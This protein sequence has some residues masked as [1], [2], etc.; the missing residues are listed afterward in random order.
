M[1]SNLADDRQGMI[2]WYHTVTLVVLQLLRI[3]LKTLQCFTDFHKYGS[4]L[5]PHSSPPPK[6][7]PGRKANVQ[8]H[9]KAKLCENKIPRRKP[10]FYKKKLQVKKK[11]LRTLNSL[12]GKIQFPQHNC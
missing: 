3:L 2:W 6:Q 8:R 5:A 9:N 4:A 7:K 11:V 10:H 12:Q 1:Y